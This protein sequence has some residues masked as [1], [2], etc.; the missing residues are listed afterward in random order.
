MGLQAK[1]RAAFIGAHQARVAH[2]VQHHDR[3][4]SPYDLFCAHGASRAGQMKHETLLSGVLTSGLVILH[5]NHNLRV[6]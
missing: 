5:L 3:R 4:Q 6:Q 2:D 1:M